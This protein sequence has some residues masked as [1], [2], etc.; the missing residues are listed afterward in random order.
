MS[1]VVALVGWETHEV[2]KNDG[3]MMNY[4]DAG[5]VLIVDIKLCLLSA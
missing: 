3:L 5:G 4:Y 2:C 1:S